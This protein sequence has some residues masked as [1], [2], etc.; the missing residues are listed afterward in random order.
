M[1]ESILNKRRPV[2]VN[3]TEDEVT[4]IL[5]DGS[6]I[7][8]PLDWHW[9]LNEATPAQRKNHIMGSDSIL[10]PDLDEGLDIEGMLRGIKPRRPYS[11]TK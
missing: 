4:V 8:N 9:W 11:V 10:W 3:F 2:A 5:S 1:T 6:K 7:S